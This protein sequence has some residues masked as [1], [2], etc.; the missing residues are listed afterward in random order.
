M[1]R[2]GRGT[3]RVQSVMTDALA[4]KTCGKVF[5]TKG[6]LNRHIKTVHL[7]QKNFK[8][9][10]CGEAFAYK[11]QLNK[12]LETQHAEALLLNLS[13]QEE[14]QAREDAVVTID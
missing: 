9:D 7:R 14:P 2:A 4:C 10:T 6:C 13:R 12:H 8:C 1:A 5:K 11:C 3:K